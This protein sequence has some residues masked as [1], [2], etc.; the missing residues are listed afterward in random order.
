VFSGNAGN[1]IRIAERERTGRAEGAVQA[2]QIEAESGFPRGE[3]NTLRRS[4]SRVGEGGSAPANQEEMLPI[5]AGSSE[6]ATEIVRAESH[7][8]IKISKFYLSK[9]LTLHG[10]RED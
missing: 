9:E 5:Q 3:Q 1:G 2:I 10:E 4:N 6:G 7:D 8:V